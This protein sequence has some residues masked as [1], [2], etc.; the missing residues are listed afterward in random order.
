MSHK[1]EILLVFGI[2]ILAAAVRIPGVFWGYNFLDGSFHNYH[3]DEGTHVRIA[4]DFLE[5]RVD[6]SRYYPKG[7]GYVLAGTISVVRYIF[8]NENIYIAGRFLSLFFGL[9]TILIVFLLAKAI[10]G[11]RKPALYSALFLGL[12]GLHVS[13]SHYATA[14]VMMT[15]IFWLVVLLSIYSITID[16]I[17]LICA[18][19]FLVGVG[20]GTKL[21]FSLLWPIAYVTYLKRGNPKIILMSLGTVIFLALGF[22]MSQGF[23]VSSEFLENVFRNVWYGNVHVKNHVKFL[24]PFFYVL[25]LIPSVGLY[26][27]W[28]ATQLFFKS[29]NLKT[30]KKSQALIIGG[31]VFLHL[32]MISTLSIPFLRHI[33]PLVPF[34]CLLAGWGLSLSPQPKL[35]ILLGIFYQI[36]FVASLEY[37]YVKEPRREAL[38]WIYQNVKQTEKVYINKRG[39]FIEP[40]GYKIVR[41]LGIATLLILPENTIFRYFRS[42]INPLSQFPDCENEVFGSRNIEECRNF[43]NLR[44]DPENS[45]FELIKVFKMRPLTPELQIFKRFYGNFSHFLG[46]VFIYARRN[47]FSKGQSRDLFDS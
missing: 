21:E 36:F 9:G 23:S 3:P 46:D 29:E 42:E 32:L 11:R 19:S 28:C 20:I 39:I 5:N 24:N 37:Y 33:L 41:D 6:H 45:P 38:D 15:F 34:V 40:Y 17:E 16:R 35:I 18:I 10:F 22:G 43:Q 2:L 4:T 1:K 12:A 13:H 26:S 8:P 25:F 27:F 7:F 44:K 31:A 47:K 30:V 14:D